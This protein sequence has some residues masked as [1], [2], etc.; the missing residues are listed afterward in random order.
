MIN[1]K[2]YFKARMIKSS[3]KNINKIKNKNI[4]TIYINYID[5][6]VLFISII[7]LCHHKTKM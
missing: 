2:T 4:K 6:F 5:L 1:F 7:S 3:P